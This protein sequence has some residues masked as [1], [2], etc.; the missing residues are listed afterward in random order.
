MGNEDIATVDRA[1]QALALLL[2]PALTATVDPLTV[3]RARKVA[4]FFAQP[5]FCAQPWTNKVGACVSTEDS[6]RE[7]AELLEGPR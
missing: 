6:L 7:C 2:D 3:Q 1:R 5:F 4:N